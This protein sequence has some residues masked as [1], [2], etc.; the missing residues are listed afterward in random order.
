M[1]ARKRKGILVVVGTAVLVAVSV[2]FGKAVVTWPTRVQMK[3]EAE[4]VHDKLQTKEKHDGDVVLIK[5][6]MHQLEESDKHRQEQ[7]DKF[8]KRQWEMLKILR[9]IKNGR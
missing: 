8:D 5:Q 3:V 6:E 4:E 1:T 2:A 7:V 9:D